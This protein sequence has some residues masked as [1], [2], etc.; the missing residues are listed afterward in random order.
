M[1]AYL[2]ETGRSFPNPIS[3]EGYTR[4]FKRPSSGKYRSHS[5]YPGVGTGTDYFITFE[6]GGPGSKPLGTDIVHYLG[7]NAE[8]VVRTEQGNG[9][10]QPVYRHFR[11]DK[12]DHKY[13]DSEEIT[14]EDMGVE[15]EDWRKAARGYNKEP[16]S[17]KP[18]FWLQNKQVA[19][20]VPVKVYYSYWPDN[21]LLH[22]GSG[23]PSGVTVGNGRDKYKYIKKLGYAFTSQ[24]DCQA[25]CGTGEIPMPIYHYRKGSYSSGQSGKTI[26]DFYTINPAAEINLS[27]GP[28]AP[29]KAGSADY[30]YQGIVG[31]C[32]AGAPVDAP[33]RTIIEGPAI[34]P[35][36]QCVDKS[37][38]YDYDIPGSNSRFTYDAYKKFDP[39]SYANYVAESTNSKGYAPTTPGV[40]S[41]GNSTD[42]VSITNED[43]HFE[44]FYGLNG[45]VKAALPRYLGF[46]DSYDSQF[47]FYLYDTTFPWNGPIYSIQYTLNNV[48]CCPNGTINQGEPVCNIIEESKSHFYEIK[49]DYWETTETR[50]RV[51]S[52]KRDVNANFYEIDT[53]TLRILFRYTTRNGDFNRGDQLNGWTISSVYYY[54]DELKVGVMNL[55]GSGNTFTYNQAIT[56]SDG[57]S[58]VVLAGYGIPNKAAFAGVYEFPKKIA[59]YKVEIDPNAL[60]PNRTLDEAEMEAVVNSKGRITDIKILNA[61]RGYKNPKVRAIDPGLL[62]DFSPTD[63]MKTMHDKAGQDEDSLK[64]LEDPTVTFTRRD[65]QRDN[66]EVFGVRDG[67]FPAKTKE[68]DPFISREAV[69]EITEINDE[70][71]IEAVRVVDGGEGYNSDELPNVFVS[72]PEMLTFNA[73][74]EPGK[75]RDV[76]EKSLEQL[77]SEMGQAW[78][79]VSQAGGKAQLSSNTQFTQ[80][81]ISSTI[82]SGVQTEIPDSYI[83]V[84]K[85]EYEKDAE[86]HLCFDLPAQCINIDARANLAK[87]MPTETQFQEV[88]KVSSRMADLEKE[89]MPRIGSVANQVDVHGEAMSHIY[90]PF[91][92]DRCI[93]MAQ[94]KLYNIQRW[95]EMPCAYL[96]QQTDP[97]TDDFGAGVAKKKRP[98]RKYGDKTRAYG[99]LPYQMCASD[100]SDE[101][102]M[103]SLEFE[104][105]TTGPQGAQFMNFLKK[106]PKPKLAPTRKV[107][108]GKKTW[109]CN[110]GSVDGRCYRNGG[111]II[112]VPV[113]LDE[114]TYDYN[115]IDGFSEY[116]QFKTWLHDNLTGQLDGVNGYWTSS[117][118][119]PETGTT[120]TTNSANYPYTRFAVDCDTPYPANECWDTFTGSTGPLQVY[121]GYDEDGDGIPGQRWWEITFNGITNPFCN[122]CP[123]LSYPGYTFYFLNGGSGAPVSSVGLTYVNDASIAIN[124]QRMVKD[125]QLTRMVLG[126][127]DGKMTVRNWLTGGTIAL[128]QAIRNFG[129]PF[130]DECDQPENGAPWQDGKTLNEE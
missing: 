95:F 22:I 83:R 66:M 4:P 35:T 59:Y 65:I 41:W 94:P 72:D 126:P 124:P 78:N 14:R 34:G 99:Y 16:R 116:Q 33:V 92:K 52:G 15:N 12:K 112:F 85:D 122:S 97:K 129:N 75:D 61:G 5:K 69:L 73:P 115:T 45:A 98:G 117:S 102:F 44:W 130:F 30:I 42:G 25:R 123:V 108:N 79:A 8:G 91:G 28:I 110:D 109:N 6:K 62:E 27:G 1:V 103:V 38:W 64:A 48:P 82:K 71:G 11:N 2:Q 56:S 36:G 58:A 18:V 77:S 87:A 89:I 10:R 40:A 37:D 96:D 125:G 43:A 100:I 118:T 121:C 53:N 106:M 13:T 113:G 51:N 17:G 101:S 88:S 120:T 24:A 84:P 20:S 107:T 119:D 55:Q 26:D 47:L 70:G 74:P 19:N 7:D 46:E 111:N 63:T 105:R 9:D 90:A 49:S 81:T 21:T 32:F 114:N 76:M 128:G 23:N 3:G 86:T 39:S 29:K 80:S 67:S 54:G 57:G 50:I 93:K 127:Y 60:I 104:G 31:Y 68:G